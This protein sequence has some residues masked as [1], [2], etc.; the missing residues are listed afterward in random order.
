M[1]HVRD[2]LPC[3]CYATY[4]SDIYLSLSVGT[5]FPYLSLVLNLLALVK[6]L[7][8]DRYVAIYFVYI[9]KEVSLEVRNS[10]YV[11]MYAQQHGTLRFVGNTGAQ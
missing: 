4:V 8:C 6:A 2:L 10:H 7:L 5:H 1:L 3:P 11:A 9:F